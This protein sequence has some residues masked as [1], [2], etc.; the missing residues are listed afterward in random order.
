M[1][2]TS[3]VRGSA[4]AAF[5]AY[6][7][8]GA[9][10]VLPAGGLLV[11]G[12]AL[13]RPA[14]AGDHNVGSEPGEG[15]RRRPADAPQPA[16]PRDDRYLAIELGHLVPSP[17]APARPDQRQPTKTRRADAQGPGPRRANVWCARR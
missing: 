4:L 17:L 9:L 16:S 8:G 12:E 6:L 14:G 10:D 5:S 2:V 15:D 11:V 13:G 1:L 7:V 3:A